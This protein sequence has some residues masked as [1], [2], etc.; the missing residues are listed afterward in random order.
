[1]KIYF[2][3]LSKGNYL[4]FVSKVM[5][6]EFNIPQR[7]VR[8]QLK[9]FHEKLINRVVVIFEYP[10]VDKHYRDSYYFYFSTKHNEIKRNSIR[11]SF[12][13]DDIKENFFYN[14]N[15]HSNLQDSFLGFITLRPTSINILGRNYISPKLFK[16]KEFV[17]MLSSFSVMIHG[18][19]LKV[20]AF[21]HCSQDGE[22]LTCAETTVLNI[23]E[24]F[25]NKYSEY[26]PILP[27]KIIKILSARAYER[28][29]PST[30]LTVDD[31]SFALKQLGFSPKTYSK[32]IE[33]EKMFK[34]ILDMYIESGIPVIGVLE[35]E[36]YEE[37]HAIII[38]GRENLFRNESR[39]T[40]FSKHDF[41]FS[42]I[43]KKYVTIDDNQ[44]PYSF[45][46]YDNFTEL[47]KDTSF[48]NFNLTNIIVP[49]YSKI[50]VD[51]QLITI[52]YEKIKEYI[53]KDIEHYS[54][55]FFLASSSSFKD[56]ISKQILLNNDIKTIIVETAMPK[57]IWVIEI[58]DK[59]GYSSKMINGIM[60][61]D[62]TEPNFGVSNLLFALS[63]NRLVTLTNKKISSKK[64]NF[65]NFSIFANN[66][67]GE[68]NSWKSY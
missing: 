37:G 11:L 18:V 60:I 56:S 36:N 28:Q 14:K 48:N 39:N 38:V 33:G 64:I 19:K 15:K 35:K 43:V 55:R 67:K 21:P 68:H 27:S 24:Y 22:T 25:G 20:D 41:N 2:K 8:K 53:L 61:I 29:L 52:Y 46:P 30:G 13:T 26:N 50:Y 51:A 6:Q 12:F 63:N 49:L 42:K 45:V 44:P 40:E 58:F 3:F 31:L 7:S 5:E 16:E 34:N 1:M 10:Y 17:L 9:S 62:A 47:Y 59:N 32:N 54:T 66:L 65:D 57:F 4:D 23:M